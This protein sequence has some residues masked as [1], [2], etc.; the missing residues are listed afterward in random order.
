[1][2]KTKQKTKKI[3]RI[4]IQPKIRITVIVLFVVLTITTMISAFATT[5]QKP[6]S[7]QKTITLCSYK[8]TGQ[9]NYIAHLKNNTVYGVKILIPG[10]GTIFK[11]ILETIDLSFKYTFTNDCQATIKGSYTLLAQINT[12]LWDKEYTL[13]PRTNFENNSFE[14]DTPLDI[15][16]YQN[17]LS[18]INDETGTMAG[19]PQLNITC[20]VTITIQTTNKTAYEGLTSLITIPLSGNIIEI[21]GDLTQSKN[22][23]FTKTI[24]IPVPKEQ[25]NQE[26]NTSLL[27]A[28]IF[29]IPIILIAV[30]TKNDDYKPTP[31]QRQLKKIK[32]KYGEWI[33]ETNKIP[34]SK[35]MNAIPVETLDD[36][37]KISE[38]T[39]KPIIHSNTKKEEKHTFYIFDE[40]I[41]YKYIL[42]IY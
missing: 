2:K 33:V 29:F 3:S 35:T 17:I 10:Q 25:H 19:K 26:R 5:E 7:I 9:F 23:A 15:F 14:I 6:S 16:H 28:A 32:K 39:G 11:K 40:N 1:M 12:N 38:E 4:K 18:S 20:R 37:L 8:Q 41:E 27:I 42:Q 34:K 21:N 22:G 30:L 13:I 31:T 24:I 36:L